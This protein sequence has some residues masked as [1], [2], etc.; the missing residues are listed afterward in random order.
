[1]KNK[2]SFSL[3]CSQVNIYDPTQ[4]KSKLQQCQSLKL[5]GP[6]G[7]MHAESAGQLSTLLYEDA[8]PSSSQ[9][10]GCPPPLLCLA[11]SLKCIQ[12]VFIKYLLCA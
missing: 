4:Q 9:C 3:L 7:L 5:T 8:L 12:Q 2:E 6:V 1:M 10:V 11:V